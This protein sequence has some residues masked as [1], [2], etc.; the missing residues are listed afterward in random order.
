MLKIEYLIE[1]YHK[2]VYKICFDMLSN[3]EEAKDICQETYISIYVNNERYK[4]LEDNEYKN[5][6]CKVALNKCR[7]VLRSRV[8]KKEELEDNI[9]KFNQFK[10]S[11]NIESEYIKKENILATREIIY[12]LKEP[13]KTV[14]Y[15]YYVYESNLDE[16]A[17]KT[18]RSKGTVKMQLHR[19]KELL[20]KEIKKVR[21]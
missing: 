17:R 18:N 1:K 8:R 9:I 20:K 16:I 6:I 21:R 3:P 19:G 15:E 10:E 2:L 13:Y 12:S 4:D 11:K 7:D 5:L 14:L